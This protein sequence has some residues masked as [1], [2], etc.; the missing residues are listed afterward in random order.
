M[1]QEEQTL[2][3]LF[4]VSEEIIRDFF[5]FDEVCVFFFP[6]IV[7]DCVLSLKTTADIGSVPQFQCGLGRNSHTSNSLASTVRGGPSAISSCQSGSSCH[8]TC[9]SDQHIGD[10]GFPNPL[11]GLH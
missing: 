3:V 6:F 8:F 4:I 2:F 5:Y 9:V 11:L 10:E 7:S 1:R